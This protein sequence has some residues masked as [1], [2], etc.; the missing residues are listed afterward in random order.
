MK[1]RRVVTGHRDGRPVVIS[2]GPAASEHVFASI[3]GMAHS[4][5]WATQ[6]PPEREVADS[7]PK[8]LRAFPSSPGEMRLN[9]AEFPPESVKA[10]PDF[11]PVVAEAE[12]RENVP[13][14]GDHS[15]WTWVMTKWFALR[16]GTLSS[17]RGRTTLGATSAQ[18]P[19]G[20]DSC[21]LERGLSKERCRRRRL[22]CG[23]MTTR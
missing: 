11:D 9:I 12:L 15:G 6:L 22:G 18:S 17:S 14:Y 10:S 16:R 5:L 23:L 8:G 2:D 21:S 19:Q 20:S 7:A 3:P 4:V 13:G 1:F